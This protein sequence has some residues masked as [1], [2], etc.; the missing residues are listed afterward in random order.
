M[1]LIRVLPSTIVAHQNLVENVFLYCPERAVT[2][3]SSLGFKSTPNYDLD[4]LGS[5]RDL[6]E[7]FNSSLREY[8]RLI[9]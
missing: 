4:L 9:K 7:D 3:K 1:K 2:N 6:L 8:L 5:K